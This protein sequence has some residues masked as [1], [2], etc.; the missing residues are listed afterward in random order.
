[1]R[2]VNG[3]GLGLFI[4]PCGRAEYVV[5]VLIVSLGLKD[6]DGSSIFPP[7]WLVLGSGLGS[8]PVDRPR[9]F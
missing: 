4:D 8:V 9:T 1:M 7:R 2:I 3:A 5:D 6:R